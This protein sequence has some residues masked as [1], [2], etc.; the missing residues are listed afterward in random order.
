M[1]VDLSK[2][3]A[4]N[5]KAKTVLQSPVSS[6]VPPKP[7]V[8]QTPAPSI[9]GVNVSGKTSA[10]TN[11]L[12][13]TVAQKIYTPIKNVTQTVLG[14]LQKPSQW[15]ESKLTGGKG[16][17]DFY[18]N[19]PTG[20]GIMSTLQNPVVKAAFPGSFFGT[21]PKV[22]SFLSS[23]ALDPLN[24]VPLA[25]PVKI[26]GKI[27]E[28]TKLNKVSKA[29]KGF[30][31]PALNLPEDLQY[32]IKMIP[33]NVGQQA[34]KYI[35]EMSPLVKNL[36]TEQ[37]TAAAH[38]LEPGVAAKQGINLKDVVAKLGKDGMDAI[39]PFLHEARQ[40]AKNQI[41]TAVQGG[42]MPGDVAKGM[43]DNGAYFHHTD[44]APA[45][46]FL[47]RIFKNG[48]QMS[49]TYWKERQGKLGYSLDAPLSVAKRQVK[50]LWDTEKL[51]FLNNL[52]S[53]VEYAVKVGR[54]EAPAGFIKVAGEDLLGRSPVLKGMA[55]R[56]DVYDAVVK[57]DKAGEVPFLNEFNKAWKP[58]VT[59]Y[60]LAFH[61][62]NMIGN[63]YQMGL[64]GITDPKRYLQAA[65]GGFSPA[66]Q[67]IVKAGKIL[68]GGQVAEA[69]AK[70]IGDVS[71]LGKQNILQK[72]G[73]SKLNPLNW[74]SSI[75]NTIENNARSATY[76]DQYN[77]ALRSGLS[78]AEAAKK[79]FMGTN[80]YLFDYMTGLGPKEK[81]LRSIFP[82]YSWTR[83]NTPLQ[84]EG[85]MKNPAYAALFGKISRAAEPGKGG[86]PDE[87]GFS[88]PTPW[89]GADG[90]NVRY[91]PNLPLNT[92]FDVAQPG[93][94]FMNM[95]SPLKNLP[96][97]ALN[98][99]GN[100]AQEIGFGGPT[101]KPIITPGLPLSEK[102]HD[103][104][105]FLSRQFR[106]FRDIQ[107]SAKLP[108]PASI[109]KYIFGGLQN[110]NEKQNILNDVFRGQS[111]QYLREQ[112]ARTLLKQGE[113]K[114]ASGLLR[115][116][117]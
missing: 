23:V 85:L 65:I 30:L 5:L 73:S 17:E 43:L 10:S 71:S 84:I 24:L 7:T 91:S 21:N 75:G 4:I 44:F 101:G 26:L 115:S 29:V 13:P 83:F 64:S 36:T 20:K 94:S 22:A 99:T 57:L 88:I 1:A 19:N 104:K 81:V 89:K 63:L 52:R 35:S 41:Y 96:T 100:P 97:L 103:A 70:D 112:R 34:E 38:L 92:L 56:K 2:I 82:F 106:P 50:Q 86:M 62:Q 78:D 8:M 77:A 32:G 6:Y 109:L 98:L 39:Q 18:S 47:Q 55:L 46:N 59:G 76:L 69:M 33:R 61:A 12:K 117:Q 54:K 37:R 40:Q 107:S 102:L 25:K 31:N 42:A 74:L 105:D 95:L 15:V 28:V 93:A 116:Q 90:G 87:R 68:N 16:Y 48:V 3:N 14:A 45:Q 27:G 80:K 60:N 11:A 113:L 114:R 49:N 110:V 51:K 108:Y 111:D 53:N 66:E 79:A 72:M 67:A 9:S 58:I